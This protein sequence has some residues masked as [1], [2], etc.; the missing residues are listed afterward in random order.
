MVVIAPQPSKLKD[1]ILRCTKNLLM[2]ELLFSAEQVN[3]SV[4]VLSQGCQRTSGEGVL[5]VSPVC[6]IQIAQ[7][8]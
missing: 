7:N 5:F 2:T 3:H 8:C 6:F 4:H 1:A